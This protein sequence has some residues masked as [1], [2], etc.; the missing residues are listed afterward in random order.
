MSLK[1]K[2]VVI[3][4]AGRGMG[5]TYTL[6]FLEEGARVVA[7]DVDFESD[8]SDEVKRIVEASGHGLVLPMD[9]TDNA[10][11]AAAYAATM[12]RFGTVDV[13]LNN[14]GLRQRN[15]FPPHGVAKVLDVTDEQWRKM[16]DVNVFGTLSVIRTFIPPMIERKSGSIINVSTT[17]TVP[18]WHRPHS[19][20]QPYMG[21]KSALTNLSLYLAYEVREFNIAVN[22]LFP[23]HAATTGTKEQDKMRREMNYMPMGIPSRPEAVVP[24]AMF[25]AE[26]DASGVTGQYLS[27]QDWNLL[28]G[29][30]GPE[31]WQ[32]QPGQY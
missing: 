30:G 14:A 10:Q 26:Q 2:V 1:D 12:E 16:F 13:L 29:L 15:L 7:T 21:A 28:H 20:E 24:L 17:G 31:A 27:A 19:R 6:G 25:L 3:T 8:G 32:A 22:V 23:P 9:L 11:I 5:R 18:A 4:G